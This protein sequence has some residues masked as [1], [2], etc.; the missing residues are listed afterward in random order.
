MFATFYGE[1]NTKV[2]LDDITKIH[3]KA[4]AF[5]KGDEMS[6]YV[7][8]PSNF[9]KI[10]KAEFRVQGAGITHI[11][12]DWKIDTITATKVSGANIG[13]SYSKY[14]ND[15]MKNRTTTTVKFD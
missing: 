2:D 10:K 8:V 4:D 3:P 9:G 6:I 11:A 15:W 12:T 14:V 5:E 7:Q 1:N 13:A